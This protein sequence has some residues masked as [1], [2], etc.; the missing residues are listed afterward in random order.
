MILGSFLS[1]VVIKATHSC[2]TTLRQSASLWDATNC[3][4][5]SHE[6]RCIQSLL[7]EE[8]WFDVHIL[9]AKWVRIKTLIKFFSKASLVSLKRHYFNQHSSLQKVFW[10]RFKSELDEQK[11]YTCS[12]TFSLPD[13]MALYRIG[14]AQSKTDKQLFYAHCESTADFGY[15]WHCSSWKP[16]CSLPLIE[17]STSHDCHKTFSRVF[18][19]YDDVMSCLLGDSENFATCKW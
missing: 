2:W 16:G 13:I 18:Q 17:A 11:S 6:T 4:I 15:A 12:Q 5:V 1:I 14:H 8:N 10:K 9:D 7:D 19:K 3:D